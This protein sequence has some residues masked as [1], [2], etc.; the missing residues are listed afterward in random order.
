[1]DGVGE[2]MVGG[3][4]EVVFG[5]EAELVDELHRVLANAS[6][7]LYG[8]GNEVGELSG[9]DVLVLE[10]LASGGL[11][12]GY[13]DGGGGYRDMRWTERVSDNHIGENACAWQD[14]LKVGSAPVFGAEASRFFA[15][16]SS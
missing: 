16:S 1:M 2:G 5:G 10:L 9:G 15:G 4:G 12:S 14:D 11:L 6:R 7:S 13:E 8:E 3:K